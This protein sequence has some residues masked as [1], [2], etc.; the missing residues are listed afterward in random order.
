MSDETILGA[1]KNTEPAAE[2]GANTDTSTAPKGGE[3]KGDGSDLFPTMKGEQGG[4]QTEAKEGEQKP[5]GDEGGKAKAKETDPAPIEVKLPE[6]VEAAPELLE[7][8]KGA[9]K[10]SAS[11]QALADAYVKVQAAAVEKQQADHAARVKSWAEE[12]KADPEFG[13]ANFDGNVKAAHRA[14][15]RFGDDGLKNFLN[16]SGLGNEPSLVRAF[17]RIGKAIAEDSV[18]GSSAPAAGKTEQDGLR[19]LFPTMFEKE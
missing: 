16:G 4:K 7:A 15:V 13:G 9:A 10:D 19:D 5:D 8:L 18:A 17:A 14:I 6:G 11:A 1:A 2:E 12:L 3:P